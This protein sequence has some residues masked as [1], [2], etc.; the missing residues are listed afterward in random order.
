MLRLIRSAKRE[1]LEKNVWISQNESI[2][3]MLRLIRSA[4]RHQPQRK[5]LPSLEIEA[6]WLPFC[7]TSPYCECFVREIQAFFLRDGCRVEERISRSKEQDVK[8][9]F[10][11]LNLHTL[12]TD[13]SKDSFGVKTETVLGWKLGSIM[14][15]PDFRNQI[16]SKNVLGKMGSI[17]PWFKAKIRKIKSTQKLWENPVF[18]PNF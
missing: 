11:V 9:F 4:K 17:S 18:N 5:I 14:S 3:N 16:N 6:K 15:W 2:A 7:R 1:P 10:P 8:S 12:K 13:P